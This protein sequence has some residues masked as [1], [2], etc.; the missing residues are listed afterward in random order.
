MGTEHLIQRAM[1]SVTEYNVKDAM[2]VAKE[3]INKKAD[4]EEIIERGFTAGIKEVGELYDNRKI[5]LPQ[6]MAS[7]AAM[8]AAMT[9]LAPE[10]EKTSKKDISEKGRIIICTIEGD[11]H[12][13]GKDIV[14]V[15]LKI[16][17]FDVINLGKDVPLMNIVQ[18]CLDNDGSA[19]CTSASMTSTMVNQKY[20]EKLLVKR[21]MRDQVITN[22]GG[23]PVTQKWADD[24]GA[25]IYSENASD[26]VEKFL[27][28]IDE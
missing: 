4:L 21:G 14:A 12:S 27:S 20:L 1:R 8:S 25:D 26:A 23:A 19:I 15:M 16:A 5:Y 24:I 2:A 11:I 18:A 3:A 6:V 13:I 9:V 7:S 28:M 17:G 22:I 10:L